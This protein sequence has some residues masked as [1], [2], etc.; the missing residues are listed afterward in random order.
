MSATLRRVV[1]SG[2]A[3]QEIESVA[4]PTSNQTHRDLRIAVRIAIQVTETDDSG[5]EIYQDEDCLIQRPGFT[6]VDNRITDVEEKE[7]PMREQHKCQDREPM[8]KSLGAA[9][10]CRHQVR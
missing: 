1:T 4:T 3:D 8:L 7:E 6:G 9:F 5:A 10:R 2:A